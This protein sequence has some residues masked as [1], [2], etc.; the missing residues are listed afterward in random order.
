V[1]SVLPAFVETLPDGVEQVELPTPFH[2]GGV[3]CY[4]LLEPPVTVIDPGTLQPGSLARLRAAL[5]ANGLDFDAV[6]QIVV[7]HA[8]ADHAGAAAVLA[9]RAEARIVC[10]LPEAASLVQPLDVALR[11]EV[12]RR[13]GVPDVVAR[14][15][16]VT[17][18]A[19]AGR[20][21]RRAH[22]GMV[23]GVSDGEILLAGGRRLD[24]IVT[25]GHAEGH[26]SLW[27]PA[28]RV[29]FSGDHLLAR[30][31]PAPALYDGDGL[32]HHSL[33]EYLASLSRFVAL[34][35]DV[36][37]PGHG[38]AFREVDVLA[39]RLHAH[40]RQRAD[41]IALLLRA[42]PATPYDVALGLQ[43]QPEGARLLFGLAHSQGHLELLTDAG[44][45]VAEDD[46][47]VLRYRLPHVAS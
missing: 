3:N 25:A 21:A 5:N 19:V 46:D 1:A 2:V 17:A 22:P 15:L 24:S 18:D 11:H 20:V 26:L 33:S 31:I 40:S 8:H 14:E 12:L 34:D 44:R 6:E 38:R 42:G 37:L 7:T 41:Q 4:V 28:A 39:A 10:A 35:P 27:D 45:A 36:V 43:W 32:R 23:H 16:V 30:I 13:L 29:L 9:A 47:G